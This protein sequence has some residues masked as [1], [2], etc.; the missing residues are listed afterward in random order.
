ME[1]MRQE[2]YNWWRQ[3]LY[4]YVAARKNM[5]I[6]QYYVSVFLAQQAV[7]KAFKALHIEVLRK[8]PPHLHD[9]F[10]LSDEFE[11]PEDI[12]EAIM[13]LNPDYATARYPDAANGIPAEQYSEAIAKR[14]LNYAKKVL[15]W[16]MS[17]LTTG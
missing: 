11:L 9:L 5:G 1:P 14:H 17:K 3:G 10:R 2:A 4:D 6:G 13:E 16:V 15:R 8:M 7:E 12:K